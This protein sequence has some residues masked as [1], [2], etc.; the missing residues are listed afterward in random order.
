MG[1]PVVDHLFS[2]VAP[3]ETNRSD[4]EIAVGL[5]RVSQHEV[6]LHRG[7][8]HLVPGPDEEDIGGAWDR[9]TDPLDHLSLIGTRLDGRTC[10]FLRR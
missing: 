7:L 10:D 8:A 5:L 6:H 2:R 1:N 9:E 3:R 4:D